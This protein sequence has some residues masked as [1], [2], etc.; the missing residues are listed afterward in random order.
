M[1]KRRTF[2][3]LSKNAQDRVLRAGREYGLDRKQIRDRYNRGTFNPLARRERLRV[4]TEFREF[5]PPSTGETDWKAAAI[6]NIRYHLSDYYK[7]NDSTML[8]A[9]E[10]LASEDVL[11][12]MALLTEDELI[13]LAHVQ[14]QYEFLPN[15]PHGLTTADIGYYKNHEW[16]NIF[17][18]H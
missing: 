7:Y 11:K 9:V 1:S 8:I 12:A 3:Q 17:W 14:S 13:S 4:P 2:G 18:Y 10:R 15:L 16:H 6:A 5:T